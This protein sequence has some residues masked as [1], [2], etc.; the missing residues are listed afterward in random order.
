MI[1]KGSPAVEI[2]MAT[3]LAYKVQS[4][5]TLL[6]IKSISKPLKQISSFV[7]Q[8]ISQDLEE[9]IISTFII[10]KGIKAS[11]PPAPAQ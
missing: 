4:H 11:V 3:G 6:A 9:D 2:T 10:T 8:I 5:W 7:D 1:I